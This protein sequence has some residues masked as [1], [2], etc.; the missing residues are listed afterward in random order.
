MIPSPEEIEA[1]GME[2]R[3]MFPGGVVP[4][5]WALGFARERDIA[6]RWVTA[7]RKAVG[8]ELTIP[9]RVRKLPNSALSKPSRPLPPTLRIEMILTKRYPRGR[10]IRRARAQVAANVGW[11]IGPPLGP[12]RPAGVP[13]LVWPRTALPTAL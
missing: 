8:L 3:E 4:L 11:V 6:V 5:G 9:S 2:L 13:V 10:R 7:A 1:L 12:A